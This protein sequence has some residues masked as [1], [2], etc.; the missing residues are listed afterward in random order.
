M[1]KIS[2]HLFG[3]KLPFFFAAPAFIWQVLFF[4]LP[5][6]FMLS[7]SFYQ[8]DSYS[9]F[10]QLH[11]AIIALRSFFL[12]AATCSL[13][14]FL[15]YPI[16]YFLSF[17]AGRTKN[18]FLFLLIVPF[19]TNFLLHIYAWFFVLERGG[20]LN[21]F[22]TWLGLIQEPIQFLNSQFAILLV[23]V[24]C[25][26]PFMALPLYSVLEKF[27]RRLIEAS[28]DLGATAWQTFIRITLPLITPGIKSGLFLVFVPA[29]GDF[30]IPALLG[31]DRSMY[32][33]SVIVHYVL[34]T[35]TLVR[36][37]AFTVTVSLLLALIVFASSI[38]SNFLTIRKKMGKR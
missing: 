26:L 16:A 4:Y 30:V 12:A 38:I 17:I 32:I 37:V 28:Y 5:I 23:M 22:L 13:C 8:I 25:Y 10:F 33:G 34:G 24:Y 3:G 19:W 7:T 31:G 6:L 14:L 29:F 1:K 9:S 2:P 27:D 21:S 35:H 36:G 11:Y 18:F 20:F 15:G